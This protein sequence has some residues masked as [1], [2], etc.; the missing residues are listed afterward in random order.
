MGIVECLRDNCALG[1]REVTNCAVVV[2][3]ALQ[4]RSQIG[5]TGEREPVQVHVTDK[6]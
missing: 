3:G 4:F 6:A 2:S 5:G 1:S